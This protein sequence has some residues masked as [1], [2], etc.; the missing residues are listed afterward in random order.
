MNAKQRGGMAL[1]KDFRSKTGNGS[2][3]RE[4]RAIATPTGALY[5]QHPSLPL[6]VFLLLFFYLPHGD[7]FSCSSFL[8]FLFPL[9]RTKSIWTIAV[10]INFLLSAITMNL[11]LTYQDLTDVSTFSFNSMFH[12]IYH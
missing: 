3:S 9:S 8:H 2:V 7:K 12:Q 4:G 6:A 10:L 11:K 1:N 5:P